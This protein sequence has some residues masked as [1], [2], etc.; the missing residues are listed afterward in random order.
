[1]VNQAFTD[2]RDGLKA[3]VRMR[4]EAWYGFPVVHAPTIFAGKVLTQVA[5]VQCGIGAQLRIALGVSIVVVNAKQER[6][7]CWPGGVT[8]GLRVENDGR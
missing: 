1:M 3:T 6:V 7:N 8:Q 2:N 5:P 4:R